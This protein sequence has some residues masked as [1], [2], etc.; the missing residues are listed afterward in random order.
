MS[1]PASCTHTNSYTGPCTRPALPGREFCGEHGKKKVAFMRLTETGMRRFDQDGQMIV[2]LADPLPYKPQYDMEIKGYHAPFEATVYFDVHT[3]IARFT[4]K[5]VF[6]AQMRG[7][8]KIL[9]HKY[10]WRH[11]L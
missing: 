3:E 4:S 11:F 9:L 7:L 1:N 2:D 8:K 5:H 10:I 6:V